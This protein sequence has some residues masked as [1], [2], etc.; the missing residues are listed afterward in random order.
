MWKY[1]GE[2]TVE[3]AWEICG[4]VWEGE[5]SFRKG[6]GRERRVEWRCKGKRIEEVK[7]FK[8]LGYVFKKSGGQEAHIGDRVKKVRVVMR[9]VGGIG[10]MKFGKDWSRS[11]W[12]FDA[13]VW[14]VWGMEPRSGGERKE[15]RLRGYRRSI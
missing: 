4:S 6:G 15:R 12:L 5:R 14:M 1:G 9:Q 13:L 11:M 3:I 8:Y 2:K 10:K 7:E